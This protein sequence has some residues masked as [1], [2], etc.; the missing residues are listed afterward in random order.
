MKISSVL[1][2]L[3]GV[4]VSGCL[5]VIKT[6]VYATPG[7]DNA[8]PYAWTCAADQDKAAK[9]ADWSKAAVIKETVKDKTYQIGLLV[10]VTG[11]PYVLRVANADAWT[12]SFR[13]PELFNKSSVLKVVLDGNEFQA[14]CLQSVA[15][16]AG[17]IAE[18]HFVPLE[19][20]YYDYHETV[21]TPPIL[22][23][24]TGGGSIGQIHVN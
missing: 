7:V 19:K 20:G 18:I 10:L 15:I 2:V 1:A 4:S 9:A 8:K 23:E 16:G 21:M 22:T 5:T 24:F 6:D 11:K 3:G 14:D 13:A 17:K 12:R